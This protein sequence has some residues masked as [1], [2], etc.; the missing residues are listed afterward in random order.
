M[1][2]AIAEA[3]QRRN[4]AIKISNPWNRKIVETFAVLLASDHWRFN[5][6]C[7]VL[8]CFRVHWNTPI[9][10]IEN[11]KTHILN[12]FYCIA[13]YGT[14]CKKLKKSIVVPMSVCVHRS[15]TN[16]YSKCWRESNAKHTIRGKICLK[17]KN[18]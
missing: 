7:F 2:A 18:W 4:A 16:I 6:I 14:V 1:N 3:F 10:C 17:L 8:F 13:F 11:I 15:K 12:W 9:K 5:R